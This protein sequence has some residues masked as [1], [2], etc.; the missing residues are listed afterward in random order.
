MGKSDNQIHKHIR[1]PSAEACNVML[2]IANVLI[3]R[4]F[5]MVSLLSIGI[6]QGFRLPLYPCFMPDFR[7][8]A[9][10]VCTLETTPNFSAC[11]PEQQTFIGFAN[12]LSKKAWGKRSFLLRKKHKK[13]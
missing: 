2:R 12:S 1:K 11:M 9:S 13:C 5:Y 10:G 8:H 6:K 7:Q 3:N 4:L